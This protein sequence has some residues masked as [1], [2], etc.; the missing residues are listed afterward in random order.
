MLQLKLKRQDQV[1]E[2]LKRGLR[3]G[4][5]IDLVLTRVNGDGLDIKRAVDLV[6]NG[7]INRRRGISRRCSR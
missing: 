4:D 7:R 1:L 5:R 2:S 6:L 3:S